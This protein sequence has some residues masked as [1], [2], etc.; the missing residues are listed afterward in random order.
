[1][2]KYVN[3]ALEYLLLATGLYLW[4]FTSYNKLLIA[5]IF[6]LFLVILYMHHLNRKRNLKIPDYFFTLGVIAIFLTVIGE[7]FFELYY[8]IIYYDKILHFFVP[9][10]LV[11]VF[12]FLATK[13]FHLENLI[14]LLAVIGL[15]TL[16]EMFEFVVDTITGTTVMQGVVINMKELTGG[17]VDT[18][19][20]LFFNLGGTLV[21]LL[22]A[23]LFKKM[24]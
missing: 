5:P 22:I 15:C 12:R 16:W 23:P 19:N 8:K 13:K 11:F 18:M 10:Y 7:F 6:P 3:T 9:I 20:D 17:F 4:I 1:M 21:G 14:I 2:V 24:G